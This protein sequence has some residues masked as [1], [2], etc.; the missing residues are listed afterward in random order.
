MTLVPV[1]KSF[2]VE[3]RSRILLDSSYNKELKPIGFKTINIT[4][5]TSRSIQ[6]NLSS[7]FIR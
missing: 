4:K 1:N 3:Q 6:R 5:P 7:I 2:K